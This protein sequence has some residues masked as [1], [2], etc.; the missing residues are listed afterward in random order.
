MQ[1]KFKNDKE[2]ILEVYRSSMN[3]FGKT[4][5]GI[6]WGSEM[7]QQ[8]RF[9]ILSDIGDVTNRKILDVGCGF[10]DLYWYLLKK[11]I[12][13]SY[14]GI[15][16][17]ESAIVE[18]KV[19]Y[20]EARFICGDI[21][22]GCCDKQT[23]DFVFASGSLGIFTPHWEEH[24]FEMLDKM[25]GLS[26]AGMAFNFLS[27]YSKFRTGSKYVDPCWMFD[28]VCKRFSRWACLRQE[29]KEN[30]FTIYVYHNQTF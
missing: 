15:D 5:R 11:Y 7:S 10:G 26:V 8:I 25:W 6:T 1:D 9:Q 19:K 28:R 24:T 20:P 23:Y 3:Q 29:Y 4:I 16:I 18:A 17:N 21:L 27:T 30:D 22:L 14:T 2:I 13:I 12:N